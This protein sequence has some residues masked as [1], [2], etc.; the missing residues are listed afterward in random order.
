MRFTPKVLGPAI[1]MH[2]TDLTKFCGA[3]GPSSLQASLWTDV[4]TNRPSTAPP[5]TAMRKVF[6]TVELRE[7]IFD[8]VSINDPMAMDRSHRAF[9]DPI[10]QSKPI[11]RRLFILPD[12]VPPAR[13]FVVVNNDIYQCG[14]FHEVFKLEAQNPHLFGVQYYWPE[15]GPWA[16]D[17]HEHD[18][19]RRMDERI[20]QAVFLD[21]Y[22]T[23]PPVEELFFE[24]RDCNFDVSEDGQRITLRKEG[25]IVIRGI[26]ER[27]N[28][29]AL[30]CTP[31]SHEPCPPITRDMWFMHAPQ[32]N[33][34]D[35][36]DL[37]TIKNSACGTG[38]NEVDIEPDDEGIEPDHEVAV[39]STVLHLF[40]AT[41]ALHNCM[42]TTEVWHHVIKVDAKHKHMLDYDY[43]SRTSYAARSYSTNESWHSH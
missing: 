27:L 42:C 25:G 31:Q 4:V 12:P 5:C 36:I 28:L 11:M 37:E 43:R 10:R 1:S 38:W 14:H 17:W 26:V 23:H 35:A 3:P 6:E 16:G 24:V 33:T 19:L 21:M 39:L 9:S 15:E 13:I 29:M 2:K 8:T 32:I 30:Y 34:I 41:K 20:S 40:P 7:L 18:N 22:L